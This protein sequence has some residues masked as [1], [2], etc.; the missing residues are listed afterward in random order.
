MLSVAKKLYTECCYA[1]CRG[2]L[3]AGGSAVVEPLTP[4]PETEGSN[5]AFAL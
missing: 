5:P 4:D 1:E 3:T 2:T